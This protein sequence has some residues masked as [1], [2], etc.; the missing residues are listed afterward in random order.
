MTRP[1]IKVT[2]LLGGALGYAFTARRGTHRSFG[3]RAT[4]NGAYFT[5][6]RTISVAE[7]IFP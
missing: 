3:W 4:Y 7:V 1:S 5:A 2:P 6:S